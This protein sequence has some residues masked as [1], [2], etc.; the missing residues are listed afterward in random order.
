M[1]A[2]ETFREAIFAV[3]GAGLGSSSAAELLARLSSAIW[4]KV[5]EEDHTRLDP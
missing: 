3:I 2:F 1:I 5:S 4:N